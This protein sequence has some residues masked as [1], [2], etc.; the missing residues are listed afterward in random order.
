MGG[1]SVFMLVQLLCDAFDLVH[2]T[3]IFQVSS[4]ESM[5]FDLFWRVGIVLA[6]S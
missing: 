6:I 4:Y 2:K 1:I 3:S 5:I